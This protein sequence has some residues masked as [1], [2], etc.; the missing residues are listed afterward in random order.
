M[1]DGEIEEDNNNNN[2]NNNNDSSSHSNSNSNSN[3]KINI[4]AEA[5]DLTNKQK[6]PY[7][8]LKDSKSSIQDM[9]AQI[10]HI[11]KNESAPKSQT[12]EYFTQIFLHLINLRQANRCILLQEDKVKSETERAKAPVDMTTLQLHNLL[13]EKSHYFKAIKACKDF[14]T[15]YPNIEMVPE[16][17]FS[18]DAPNHIKSTKLSK[19]VN[20]DLMM[21]RLNYELYQRK[22]L[23]KLKQK[24]ESRKKSLKETIANRKKF[25]SS[26][27]SHLKSLKKASLPVQNHLGIQHTK[28]LKQHQ[29]AELLPPPLYVVYTQFMAH[30]EAFGENIDLEILGSAKDAHSFAR[31][32]ANKNNDI[33]NSMESS[34]VDDDAPDE[35]DDNQRRRKR[36]RKVTSKENLDQ[37]RIYQVHPLKIILQIYDDVASSSKSTTIIT[38]NFEYLLK[39]NVVCVGVEGSHEG[40]E[41]NILC[42]LFPDDTGLELPNQSGKLIVG[43]SP[44]FDEKRISRPFKWAQHLAGIDLLPEVSPLLTCHEPENSDTGKTD[45]EISRLALYRQQ[46]RVQTVV[47]RI[48]ARKMSQQA[49]ML[50]LDLLAKL[51]WPALNCENIPWAL[52]TRSCNLQEW[53]LIGSLSSNLGTVLP[54]NDSEQVIEVNMNENPSSLKEELE[55]AREDGELPSLV[56]P[57]PS[58]ED[59]IMLTPSS[60]KRGQSRQ[61]S[62]ISKSALSPMSKGRSPSFKN[63]DDD[64]DLLLDADS[65]VDEPAP[66]EPEV[67]D[68]FSIQEKANSWINYGVREFC[69]VLT[70]K[71]DAEG[72]NIVK[73]EAKIKISMEYPL[74]PPLF[75]LSLHGERDDSERYNELRAM[76]AEVNLHILRMVPLDEEKNILAHQV[77]CLAMLFDYLFMDESEKQKNT[78]VLDVG[79]CK[80]VS[81]MLDLEY[82]CTVTTNDKA[83]CYRENKALLKFKEFSIIVADLSRSVKVL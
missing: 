34:R 10:L 45:G 70:R 16:E 26:L 8:L 83:L 74:R 40:P 66:V 82:V 48:R 63:H 20:H 41:K 56:Q 2:Y 55:S 3:I 58:A 64:L 46:N 65:D 44:V 81:G 33:P 4:A 31:Q 78:C 11:K 50:Q 62:L 1:E 32:Q 71:I 53:S 39:L 19:D 47:Q 73:L 6:S 37:T 5:T 76:E 35:E 22:D 18:R 61:L 68:V 21:K 42:N 52:H 30:K 57:I 59:D 15:K 43:N 27:P 28:K 80:P 67:E 60:S 51:E 72:R 24:L 75:T 79:L 13:Y 17:E 49:L 29:L 54:I 9:V 12:R 14:K 23:C 36:P 7:E 38:L 25:L 77:H 69:L